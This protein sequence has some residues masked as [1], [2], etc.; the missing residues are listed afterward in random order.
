MNSN[1]PQNRPGFSLTSL[2][3]FL[4]VL[5]SLGAAAWY[6][7]PWLGFSSVEEMPLMYEVASGDF[8]HE[9]TESGEV[10]SARNVE[11]RCEV[12]GGST[13]LEIVPEG[14]YVKPGDILAKLDHSALDTDRTQQEITCN[15]SEAAKITAG[16]DY[17]N[18]ELALL[19][20]KDG[21]YRQEQEQI[22]SKISVAEENLRRAKDYYDY[23]KKLAKRGYITKL[24]LE[25][26]EFAIEKA[27]LDKQAAET[28][29][30]VLEEFTKKKTINELESAIKS[31]AA[32]L[33]SEEASHALDME[34]LALI[35]SQIEKCTILAEQPGQVV[36]ANETNRHGGQEVI[37]EAGVN[38][39]E[40]QT[41]IRLPDPKA[42]QVI[43]KI[44]EAKVTFVE[45]GMPVRIHMDAYPDREFDGIVEKV[46]EYPAAASWWAGS[47]KEYETYIKILGSPEGLKPGLSAEV[48]VRVE[49]L[50]D[51][52]FVPVQAVFE[53]AKKH[54][55][56][57][58]KGDSWKARE[59][60]IGSTN[61]KVVVIE[62][63]LQAD[64]QI[65]LGAFA[66]HDRVDLP[67]LPKEVEEEAAVA[68]KG[69]GGKLPGGGKMAAG[70]QP[71]AKKTNK[72]DK[73]PR[74]SRDMFAELDKDRDGKISKDELPAQ[75]QQMMA[76]ADADKDGS[77]SRSEWELSRE[78]RR[79]RTGGP[80]KAG[81]G[82]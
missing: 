14:T 10:K 38:V 5:A 11:I 18:A 27:E 52:V 28:E 24:R 62:K 55:C 63:G 68:E 2:L 82:S 49:H 51:V 15:T 78:K 58:R 43:A 42:M 29:L 34:R 69:D 61:D 77:V 33:K 45:E 72:T 48:R 75:M 67:D 71:S 39:R 60:E 41:I 23:S 46:N 31:A 79:P 12:Q 4:V 73:K 25:A 8:F 21:K 7:L 13:I 35:K 40:R 30:M 80:K 50:S 6:Y 44:N 36:Y 16:T 17:T 57:L 70:R 32:N 47:V 37:I 54:Y 64:E 9:I 20:Y 19:E 56:V 3:G 81:A 66:Y 65:V 26:D 1:L 22:N 59:V 74:G 53:H 76:M